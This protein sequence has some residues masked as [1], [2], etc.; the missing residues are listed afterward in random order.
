MEKCKKQ[1]NNTS[2]FSGILQMTVTRGASIVIFFQKIIAR[3]R[4]LCHGNRWRKLWQ[5]VKISVKFIIDFPIF[6]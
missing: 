3:N 4:I 1:R 2:L 6:I 5:I